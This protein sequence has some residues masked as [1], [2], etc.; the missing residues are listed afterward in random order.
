MRLKVLI[1]LVLP[2]A[3]QVIVACCGECLDTILKNYSNKIMTVANLDNS[4][5]QP[6]VTNS[7]SV[8]KD[9][10]GIKIN[11][12]RELVAC[13]EKSMLTFF[14]SAYAWSCQCPPT[15]AMVAK[16]SIISFKV[17]TVYDFDADHP[18][19]SD[20]SEFFRV[21]EFNVYNTI[22]EY[23]NFQSRFAYYQYSYPKWT[24]FDDEQLDFEITLL[25]MTPPKI[26]TTNQFK[27]EIT[28]SDGR[29]FEQETT[30]IDFI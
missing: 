16:D 23:L 18:A 6:V 30:E 25:L 26:K 24:L 2:F 14:S 17:F 19:N 1:L 22:P 20:V 4:G 15:L 12:Q 10:Y 27:I 8:S 5:I 21:P 29:I 3:A 11:I 9:A 28:L 13:A 7:S